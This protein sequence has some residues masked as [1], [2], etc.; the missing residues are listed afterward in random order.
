VVIV[1][2]S[3]G[4]S[5]GLASVLSIA[6]EFYL[7]TAR[8]VAD[9]ARGIFN[10]A[11]DVGL[12]FPKPTVSYCD[13]SFSRIEKKMLAKMKVRASGSPTG[14]KTKPAKMV[15][16]RGDVATVDLIPMGRRKPNP[17][18][19]WNFAFFHKSNTRPGDSGGLIY[20]GDR[21]VAIH[22]GADMGAAQNVAVNLGPLVKLLFPSSEVEESYADESDMHS[23]VELQ[24]LD[25]DHIDAGSVRFS[26]N[27][28]HWARKRPMSP[29]EF[30]DFVDVKAG[31]WGDDEFLEQSDS[32]K[33]SPDQPE[34]PDFR[35]VS[36]PAQPS[37]KPPS[38]PA[39]NG[40]AKK[41]RN[42]K[43]RSAASPSSDLSPLKEVTLNGV[44]YS[45][46]PKPSGSTSPSS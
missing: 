1:S 33:V 22:V 10:F 41:K 2:G 21:P 43:R 25:D 11:G 39:S 8:H 42:R 46:T 36:P 29:R 23:E 34:Q 44:T 13:V 35:K 40:P 17:S 15:V 30:A 27:G 31:R 18:S 3:G 26:R 6:G 4:E 24:L 7:V 14:A 38:A 32:R 45:L 19:S 12:P 16:L 20:Q 28:K 9:N 37:S 5:L